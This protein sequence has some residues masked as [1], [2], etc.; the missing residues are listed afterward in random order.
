ML[1]LRQT[2]SLGSGVCVLQ[3]HLLRSPL[4]L[5]VV[6]RSQIVSSSTNRRAFSPSLIF[7]K[8]VP[9]IYSHMKTLPQ[10]S[11]LKPSATFFAQTP[12]GSLYSFVNTCLSSL[13][14]YQ[15]LWWNKAESKTAKT[16]LYETYF[17]AWP[18]P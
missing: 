1:F 12:P 7:A 3:F 4:A 17:P 13:A 11:H 14:L 2:R 6:L 8:A 10:P 18:F 9:A 5:G 16:C 15:A